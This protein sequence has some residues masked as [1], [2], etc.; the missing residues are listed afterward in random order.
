DPRVGDGQRAA[1][2][3]SERLLAARGGFEFTT[4]GNGIT[5]LGDARRGLDT[6]GQKE[7]KRRSTPERDR[8]GR[9]ERRLHAAES[10]APTAP[11]GPRNDAVSPTGTKGRGPTQELTTANKI[12]V[13]AARLD[14]ERET[15]TA[16]DLIVVAWKKFPESFGLT[17]YRDTY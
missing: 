1:K 14:E 2:R 11:R 16:E 6:M 8:D 15:F 17:G 4:M 3:D 9:G 5:L 12:M 13:A 10:A 7:T